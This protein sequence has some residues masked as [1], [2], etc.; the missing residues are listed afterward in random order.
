MGGTND[1][2]NLITLT[3][4][5]HAEEHRK[6]WEKN[7]RMED[8]IAWLGLSKM[9]DKQ[10]VLHEMSKVAGNK[11]VSYKVGIHNPDNIEMKKEGGRIAIQKM[12]AW[13]KR[14]RW[15]NNEKVDTR[16]S[17]ENVNKYL[18][19]GWKFGRLF[20][21]NRGKKNI[22]NNLF[23]INKEGINKRVPESQVI[24]YTNNGW[25]SGMHFS[26]KELS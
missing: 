2:S 22:T 21:P 11:T 7:K 24:V 23:W 6:L 16:V 8:K 17:S 18:K 14:S 9:I 12:P 3:V 26:K 1:S 15:M 5:E 4:E 13:T 10:D 25:L 20:S 19:T